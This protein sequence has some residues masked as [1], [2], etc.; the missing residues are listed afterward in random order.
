[1]K[2]YKNKKNDEYANDQERKLSDLEA[3]N[4]TESVVDL[5]RDRKAYNIETFKSG[6]KIIN[7]WEENYLYGRV[8]FVRDT[9]YLNEYNLL[10]LTAPGKT[11]FALNFVVDAFEDLRAHMKLKLANLSNLAVNKGNS[12]LYELNPVK[13]WQSLPTLYAEHLKTISTSF[14]DSFMT[15]ARDAKVAD[16]DSFIELY[17]ESMDTALEHVP[18]SM[19]A[20]TKSRF[21]PPN[22]SGLVIELADFKKDD[23][24]KKNEILSDNNFNLF[25]GQAR[26]FGFIVDKN[27]PYRLVADIFSPKMKEYMAKRGIPF[28]SNSLFEY[29]YNKTNMLEANSL[30][31][32][33]AE[34]YNNYVLFKPTVNTYIPKKQ[35]TKNAFTCKKVIQ[36]EPL[37]CFNKDGHVS[38]NSDFAKKFGD[39]FWIRFYFH[40]RVR[41]EGLHYSKHIVDTKL[42]KVYDVYKIYGL[43]KTID[44][45]NRDLIKQSPD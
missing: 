10:Q 1:M 21:C 34:Q 28:D 41:E 22:I 8:N 3:S 31:H 39:L 5:F 4:K 11:L 27:C 7:F 35:N 40:L 25:S 16:F 37:M 36:R 29:F 23:D 18:I 6:K 12:F 19:Q 26:K 30:R 33:M 44:K 17:I 32:Y 14:I 13:A 43:G 24:K 45:I 38:P 20:F 9:V 2:Y 15:P 42:K